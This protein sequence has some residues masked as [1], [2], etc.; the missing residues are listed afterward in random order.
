M[1]DGKNSSEHGV[2]IGAHFERLRL[3]F[4][5]GEKSAALHALAFSYHFRV[6]PPLWATTHLNDGYRRWS[7]AEVR[8]L[9]AALGIERPKGF[10]L[11]AANLQA[12]LGGTIFVE[13]NRLLETEPYDDEIFAEVG[14]GWGIGKTATKR[15]YTAQLRSIEKGFPESYKQVISSRLKRK[16]SAVSANKKD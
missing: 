1:E 16:K 2:D 14:N 4:D 5:T 8:T 9:D 3:S 6:E 12:M 13:V 15:I 10:R 7:S 11:D